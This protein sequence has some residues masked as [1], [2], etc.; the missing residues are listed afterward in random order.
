MNFSLNKKNI[1]LWLLVILWLGLIFWLSA[2]PSFPVDLEPSRHNLISFITHLF[3]YG[4]LTL[5]AIKAFKNSGVSPGRAVIYGFL[6]SVIYGLLDEGHQ[7]FVDG[8]EARWSDW[9]LDIIG[10]LVVAYYYLYKFKIK[11]FS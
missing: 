8:R 10:S 5:L 4:V 6:L 11:I 2:Q 1:Y 3:L 7:F 9:L